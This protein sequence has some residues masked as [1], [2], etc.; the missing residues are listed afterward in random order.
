MYPHAG[1]V[2]P[3]N[4]YHHHHDRDVDPTPSIRYGWDPVGKDSER[5]PWCLDLGYV[6]SYI[7]CNPPCIV[8]IRRKKDNVFF[9]L[10]SIVHR[11]LEG[12]ISPTI[13]DVSRS[14]SLIGTC[15][16]RDMHMVDFIVVYNR[17]R[18][19]G[20]YIILRPYSHFDPWS[21]WLWWFWM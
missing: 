7:A 16:S 8:R 9:S 1:I 14:I 10:V 12:S 17:I 20:I 19:C 11:T 5:P 3:M 18:L 13:C 2:L 15:V 6:N 21:P 4:P